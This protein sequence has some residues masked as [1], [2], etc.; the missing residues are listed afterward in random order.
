[1]RGHNPWDRLAATHGVAGSHGTAAAHELA[2][3]HGID[4]IH[5]LW[6][7]WGLSKLVLGLTW[8]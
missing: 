5:D 6:S 4:V 3:T 2:A 1:M 7:I 8:V